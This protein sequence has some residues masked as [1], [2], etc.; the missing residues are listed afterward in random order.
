MTKLPEPKLEQVRFSPGRFIVPET[1]TDP[2]R[3]KWIELLANFPAQLRAAVLGLDRANLDRPYRSDGK[4]IRQLVHYL[5][6]ANVLGF[7]QFK[8][9]LSLKE[10]NVLNLPNRAWLEEADCTVPISYSIQVLRGVHYRW[11]QLLR[12]LRK[13]DWQQVVPHPTQRDTVSL[14]GVLAYYAWHCAHHL[15]QITRWRRQNDC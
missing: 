1:V 7:L 11:A 9:A 15:N 14:D 2:I 6:D 8:S 12:K 4:T 10:A 13:E 3:Q 5:S